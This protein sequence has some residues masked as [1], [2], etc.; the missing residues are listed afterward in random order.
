MTDKPKETK[1]TFTWGPFKNVPMA[2]WVVALA[3][4]IGLAVAGVYAYKTSREILQ[5]VPDHLVKFVALEAAKPDEA[6]RHYFEDEGEDFKELVEADGT[7]VRYHNIDSCHSFLFPGEDTPDFMFHP[8]RRQ[9]IVDKA[10]REGV[11]VALYG[12]AHEYLPPVT[13]AL[14]AATAYQ[15]TCGDPG[16][17]CCAPQHLGDFE[18]H[19]EVIEACTD[20]DGNDNVLG[21]LYTVFEDGCTRRRLL[22]GCTGEMGPQEW[23]VCVHEPEERKGDD[24]DSKSD[25]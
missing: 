13:G 23:L 19:H 3:S 14:F 6:A 15:S 20:E 2:G 12:L 16:P 5:I 25:N 7:Q 9:E 10:L 21:W 8:K 4:L 11:A 1:P 18:L 24:E 17:G 22:N